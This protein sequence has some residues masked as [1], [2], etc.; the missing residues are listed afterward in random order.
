[1]GLG[2]P[3]FFFG[4]TSGMSFHGGRITHSLEKTQ[5]DRMIIPLLENPCQAGQ[6]SS[7]LR[8]QGRVRHSGMSH[9]VRRDRGSLR[10]LAHHDYWQGSVRGVLS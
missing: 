3:K 8:Q 6:G 4:I 2:R 1:M 7:C 9:S 10:R 5:E